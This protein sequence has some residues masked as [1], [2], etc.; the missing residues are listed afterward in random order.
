MH[1]YS[2]THIPALRERKRMDA[3]V[4]DLLVMRDK[5]N[6]ELKEMNKKKDELEDKVRYSPSALFILFSLIA[7]QQRI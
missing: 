4:Q 5:R 7:M 1:T 2:Y 3:T 6:N